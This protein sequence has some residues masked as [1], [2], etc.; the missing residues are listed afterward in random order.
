MDLALIAR[1]TQ[2]SNARYSLDLKTQ[3]PHAR[4]FFV[5]TA[6]AMRVLIK[7]TSTGGGKTWI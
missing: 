6:F 7:V 2:Q 3:M 4:M 1:S 5:T